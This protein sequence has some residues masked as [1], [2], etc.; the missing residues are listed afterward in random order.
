MRAERNAAWA[1]FGRL[2]GRNAEIEHE[3]EK[4]RAA[5]LASRPYVK[6]HTVGIEADAAVRV[7]GQIRAALQSVQ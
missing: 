2:Q 1:E 3:N 5:L 7:L 6:R 4:L